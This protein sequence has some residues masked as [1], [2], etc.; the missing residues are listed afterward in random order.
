VRSLKQL[1][2]RNGKPKPHAS[3]RTKSRWRMRRNIQNA[4]DENRQSKIEEALE[5][6]RERFEHLR[7]KLFERILGAKATAKGKRVTVDL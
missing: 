4:T 3:E 6:T 2:H 1:A 5:K 7:P